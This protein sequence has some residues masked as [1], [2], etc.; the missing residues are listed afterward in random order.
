M[1]H[2]ERK[3]ASA[4]GPCEKW[5]GQSMTDLSGKPDEAYALIERM[6]P[7]LPK[8]KLFARGE[9]RPGWTVW[10]NEAPGAAA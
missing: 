10:G 2:Y 4:P 6:Y 3:N 8:I 5:L 7:E 9:V 1:A